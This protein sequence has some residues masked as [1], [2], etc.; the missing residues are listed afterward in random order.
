[1]GSRN[2]VDGHEG[3]DENDGDTVKSNVDK[4]K[5]GNG[6]NDHGG[7]SA[8]DDANAGDDNNDDGG[9]RTMA[10]SHYVDSIS[11]TNELKQKKTSFSI[12]LFLY[13]SHKRSLCIL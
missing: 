4:H 1:M 7:N 5:D 8:N 3:I 6:Y 9:M 10:P 13:N 2:D 11:L 12:L